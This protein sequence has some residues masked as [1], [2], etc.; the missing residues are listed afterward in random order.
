MLVYF[1]DLAHDHFKV[2][3]YTPTGIGY[4]T[5]YSKFK[6]G[7]RVKFHL[8]KSVNK[9]LNAYEKNKPDM[10]GFSNY[11]WNTGLSKFAGELIKK[12]D[13]DL[14]IIMGGPNIRIDKKGIETFLKKTE[15]VDTYCMFAGEFSVYEILN[16]L[17]SHLGIR[18]PQII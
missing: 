3:Q 8:F 7:N 18:G 15:Y 2:N 1:A 13:P 9:L 12:Q 17:L 5:A 6:L 14:P 11:T 4:I 10:V 16:F